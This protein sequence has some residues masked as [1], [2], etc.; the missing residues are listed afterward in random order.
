MRFVAAISLLFLAALIASCGRGSSADEAYRES[1][2]RAVQDSVLTVDNLPEG[3]ARSEIG[4]QAL[5]GLALN[6]DCAA[7]NGRGA[8]FP[9]EVA[10]AD[11]E[12]FAGPHNQ[13]LAST[14]TAFSDPEAARAA[15][16]RAN[17]L[18]LQC[19]DQI[20]N[21]L[22]QAIQNAAGDLGRLIGSISA[23]VE[24]AQY[25]PLGDETSAYSLKAD[26]STLL[27]SIDVNGHILVMRNG[28]LTG[29]LL[30]ATLGDLDAGEEEGIASA[31]STKINTAE[32][33]LPRHT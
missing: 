23:A 33:T 12:P 3:W 1:A 14:V 28:P 15:V 24:P 18:V 20:Q 6:G 30:Y 31:L 16:R 25:K 11:S 29:V 21:A 32:Q 22:K 13:Q 9:G 7:L 26:I 2:Q 19:R 5:A 4:A 10:T 27:T 17:D 8:G